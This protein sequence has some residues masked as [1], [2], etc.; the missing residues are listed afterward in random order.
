MD[1]ELERRLREELDRAEIHRVLL[2][3]AR[4]L[5]RLDNALALSLIHI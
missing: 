5:D 2:R 4:G 1:A 3:Y